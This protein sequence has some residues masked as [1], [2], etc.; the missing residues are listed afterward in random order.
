MLLRRLGNK[1]KIAALIIAHFPQHL[2]YIELFFGA[3]GLF[4]NKPLADHNFLNDLDEDVYNLFQVVLNE[5]DALVEFCELMPIHN[6]LF[7]EWRKK[8]ETNP[9]RK[10][11]RFLMLSNFSYLGMGDTLQLQSGNKSKKALLKNAKETLKYIQDCYFLNCDFRDVLGKISFTDKLARANAFI[12]ADPPYLGTADNYSSSFK[13]KD[14]EDL[15][16][17][18]VNSG[19]R[20]AISEFKNPIILDLAA[21][22]NLNVIEIAERHTLKS[23]NIEILIT[24]Y[25][26]PQQTLFT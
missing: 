22:H 4:F 8:K 26:T 24:N 1:S 12:Y 20:F 2:T 16:Q 5:Y 13:L 3:G 17:I 14:T 15:F 11:A 9:L 25:T 7:Q 18:L 6:A 21:N 10:A 19:M 23:R